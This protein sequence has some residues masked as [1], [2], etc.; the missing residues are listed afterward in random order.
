[1]VHKFPAVFLFLAILLGALAAGTLEIAASRLLAATW[2]LWAG[3]VLCYLRDRRH[4]FMAL[5]A[6]TAFCCGLT[7]TALRLHENRGNAVEQFAEQ[8]EPVA[9]EGTIA[10]SIDHRPQ[11]CAFVLQ[12]DSLFFYDHAP[13]AVNGRI[14]V[15]VLQSSEPLRYGDRIVMRGTLQLPSAARNPGEFD[16]RDHLAKQRI[17][18]TMRISEPF[19]IAR[20]QGWQGSGLQRKII[21]PARLSIRNTLARTLQGHEAALV[22]GLLLGSRGEIDPEI[23]EAFS[24]VGVIHVLAVSGLHVAFFAGALL[25]GLSLLRVPYGARMILVLAGLF[26]YCQLTGAHPPVVRASIM[27]GILIGGYFFQRHSNPI[28]SLAVAAVVVWWY[29]PLELFTASF[30]L[31]FVAVIGIL[32]L[33][34]PMQRVINR[35]KWQ[36]RGGMFSLAHQVLGLLAVSLAAQLATAPLIALYFNRIPLLA[37]P[38]NCLVVPLTGVT[39]ALGYL[40]AAVSPLSLFVGDCY[41]EAARLTAGAMI[42]IVQWANRLPLAYTTLATP[43]TWLL[44]TYA[45]ALLAIFSYPNRQWRGKTLIANLIVW[46]L[47][48]WRSLWGDPSCPLV[49][50]LDV[51][52]GDAIVLQTADRQAVLIDAGDCTE[53]WDSGRQTIVPFLVRNGIRRLHTVIITHPHADHIG[54]LP[55]LLQTMRIDRL[56]YNRLDLDLPFCSTIDSLVNAWG[57]PV[58]SVVAGDTLRG[59]DPLIV[60]VL[61]PTARDLQLARQNPARVNDASIV[62]RV[63]TGRA[64]MLLLGD[65]EEPSEQRLLRFGPLI[66]CQLVKVG[67]HGSPTASSADFVAAAAPEFA[68]V[69]VGKNN[70]FGLP[71][72]QALHTWRS[73]GAQVYCTDICGCLQFAADGDEWRSIKWRKSI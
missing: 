70:R 56:I 61:H 47:I 9:V 34:R 59:P 58:Q 30:Q 16:Y 17:T 73:T 65:A 33:Y 62:V 26:F 31:S 27:L 35:L 8:S 5:G 10:S 22:N 19:L 7:I 55:Y 18:A 57:V 52:Q 3:T 23:K 64:S 32:V 41:A 49:S 42:E 68:V 39:V 72:P 4:L 66:N 60:W 48:V 28:N 2:L 1:M 25:V 44:F 24:N 53:N 14:W 67:H 36:N 38:I 46:N 37:L 45:L 54:G 71:S 69:S 43:S 51:G 20:L 6:V 15:R 63:M 29:N 11:G 21:D 13:L 12:A 40:A 50:F